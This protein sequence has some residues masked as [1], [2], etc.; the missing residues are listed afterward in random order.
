MSP[1]FTSRS[2]L[3]PVTEGKIRV[4]PLCPAPDLLRNLGLD[5]VEVFASVDLDPSV[6]DDPDNPIPFA[7]VGQL[8][9]RCVERTGCD[10]FGLLLGER[11]GPHTL[12]LVGLLMSHANDV[13]SALRSAVG[14]LHLHDRGA[15]ASL[16]VADGTAYLGYAVAETDIEGT[17]Q[18]GATAIGIACN[19]MRGLCGAEWAPSEVRLARRKP[20][21]THPYRRF[22]R[23]PVRFD[24]AQNALVFPANWLQKP[25][26]ETDPGLREIIQR[27]VEWLDTRYGADFP[28]K[29]RRVLRTWLAAG[30]I[31]ADRVAELFAMHRR[32]LGRHLKAAG[33]TFEALVDEGRYT[34]A[35]QLL[36]DT[37]LPIRRI[38]AI[39]GYR[40]ETAFTRAFRRWAAT[41]PARWRSTRRAG[42]ETST[43][44]R[45]AR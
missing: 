43:S 38:A 35:R 31:S 40:D 39:V 18:I 8:V 6:L 1:P 3:Q 29:V 26:P 11:G 10:H 30:E 7:K 15:V 27:E 24:S 32:T 20:A 45:S 36:T 12:G 5:P 33:T 4:A 25:L 23:A 37:D 17:E 34:A 16:L 2:A 13:G 9:T 28:A 44:S 21:N 42:M 41:S 19:I 22:F 14:Y